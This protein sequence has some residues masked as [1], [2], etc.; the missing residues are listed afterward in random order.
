MRAAQ[1]PVVNSF[2]EPT[3]HDGILSLHTGG[4]KTVCALYIA[5]RLKLPTLVIVHN[6]FLR[7]Q[8]IERVKMFLPFAR[9]WPHPR[10]CV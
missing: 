3:P 6:S 9:S 10:R 4:G 7:D 5:S 8:W 2:L 1:Q